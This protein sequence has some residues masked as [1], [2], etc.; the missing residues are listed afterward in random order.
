MDSIRELTPA[1]ASNNYGC[2]FLVWKNNAKGHNGAMD[3]TNALLHD[4][5][6]GG[7]WVVVM[8]TRAPNDNFVWG[9]DGSLS[10]LY[11]TVHWP[12][13]NLFVQ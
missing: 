6:D 9:L 7:G 11:G 3:G 8:N 12:Q 2:G 13:Y 4:A 10:V 1:S 5:G